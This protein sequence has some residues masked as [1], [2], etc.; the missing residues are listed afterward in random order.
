MFGGSENLEGSKCLI[1]G[2]QQYI[3]GDTA[4][5]SEK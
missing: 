4:S 5:Q 2:E 1:L 3:I